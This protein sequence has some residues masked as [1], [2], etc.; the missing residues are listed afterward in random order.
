MANSAQAP[1]DFSHLDFT[2]PADPAAIA[3]ALE[4]HGCAV[5]RGAMSGVE[6]DMARR[7]V[8]ATYARHDQLKAAKQ[9][10]AVMSWTYKFGVLSLQEVFGDG[11]TIQAFVQN[12]GRNAAI[13]AI[14]AAFFKSPLKVE[15]PRIV[16][17]RQSPTNRNREIPYHQDFYTQ[18]EGVEGVLNFWTPFVACGQDAPSVEVVTHVFGDLLP[19]R[20]QPLI[21]E[22]ESF[23]KIHITRD[24]IIAMCGDNKFWHPTLAEGD[25]LIFSD[26]VIHRTYITETMTNERQS[27]EYRIVSERSVLPSY[28]GPANRFV[29]I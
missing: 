22:N 4:S 25:V 16:F 19:T 13:Q 12:Y 27:L 2:W 10:P 28:S 7:P 21:P 6:L 23:D 17:R 5:V 18:T 3:V 1:D 29:S 14:G 8:A 11:G 20:E 9:L 15:W 24:Q 26:H